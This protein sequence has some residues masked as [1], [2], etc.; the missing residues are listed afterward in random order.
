MEDRSLAFFALE[1]SIFVG[2]DP[3]RGPWHPDFAMLA[4]WLDSLLVLLKG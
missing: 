4:M 2:L 3:A 1:N